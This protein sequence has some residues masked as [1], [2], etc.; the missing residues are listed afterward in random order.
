MIENAE[1]SFKI[2]VI[3]PV[4]LHL[5]KRKWRYND[6]SIKRQEGLATMQNL[7]FL[8]TT[9]TLETQSWKL[10]AENFDIVRRRE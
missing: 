9:M 7:A 1:N 8:L 3:R 2:D 5:F 6:L 10:D 4:I